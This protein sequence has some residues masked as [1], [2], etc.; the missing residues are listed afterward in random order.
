MY[1]PKVD[2]PNFLIF[3]KTGHMEQIVADKIIMSDFNTTLI[4]RLVTETSKSKMYLR[5]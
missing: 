2:A 3:R 4:S 5:F 1:V